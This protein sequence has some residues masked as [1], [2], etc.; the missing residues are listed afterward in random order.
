[1]L[2]CV[3]ER[4]PIFI[5]TQ[6]IPP[7]S[8]FRLSVR[9]PPPSDSLPPSVMITSTIH[10]IVASAQPARED[11]YAADGA[12]SPAKL[13]SGWAMAVALITLVII[14]LLLSLIGKYLW[15]SCVCG[16][17]SGPGLFTFAKR[18]DNIWQILGLYI[19]ASLMFGG[20]VCA[21]AA[22]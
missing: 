5:W 6:G 20:C 9:S 8:F 22:N 2:G 17:G 21:P 4:V 19:L 15:N 13:N 12:S 18:A 11:F 16:A 14:I 1:M 10:S 3:G 7:R